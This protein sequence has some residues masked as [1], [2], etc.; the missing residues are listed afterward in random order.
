MTVNLTCNSGD[1]IDDID[2]FSQMCH[3]RLY[4]GDLD[5][6]RAKVESLDWECTGRDHSD[7]S[8]RSPQF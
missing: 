1:E 5:G 4:M 6:D 8:L 2:V 3:F 7:V